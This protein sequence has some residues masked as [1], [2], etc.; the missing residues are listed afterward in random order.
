[1]KSKSFE[2][3]L[4]RL[5]MIMALLFL[6]IILPMNVWF[7]MY[8]LHD[9][10]RGS[11]EEMFGQ[12]EQ[13]MRLNTSELEDTR[14]EFKERCIQAADAVAFCVMLD[15][16][17]VNDREK[18]KE[19][20]KKLDIDEIHYF[21]PEG[22]IYE[23]THPKYFGYT[24]DSGE[25][26]SF[27]KPMLQDRTLK[28]CQ[29][30]TPNTAEGKEMQYAAV[31][32]EDGSGIVQIGMEPRRLQQEMEEKDLQNIIGSFPFE[33]NGY[34]HIIDK[35][36][37][38][39]VASTKNTMIGKEFKGR[40]KE[41]DTGEIHSLH[42]R[43]GGKKYC[44]YLKRYG[45]YIFVR[46]YES[47]D[48]FYT[49]L[50]S[51]VLIVIY[52]IL[53]SFGIIWMIRWYVKNKLV[54]GL[55]VINHELKKIEDGNMEKITLNTG[56]TEFEELLSYINRMLDNIRSNWN[57]FSYIMD[58]GGIPIGIYEKNRFYK[59]TF[60][61]E[62]MTEILGI[63]KRTMLSEEQI[64]RLVEEKLR[65]AEEKEVDAVE[66]VCEYDRDGDIRHL[67]IE[68]PEDEQSTI[69]YVTDI[70]FWWEEIT[71]VKE[72]SRM[73]ELTG[74]YNRRGFYEKMES[75][76]KNPETCG[77]AAMLMID[78]DSLKKINDTLG[79]N[80]GDQYLKAIAASLKKSSGEY[81]VCARL[82]GDEFVVFL[83]GFSGV[84]ELQKVILDMK[85]AR[86][87][88]FEEEMEQHGYHLQFSIGVSFYP[89]D[90]TDF[91]LLMQIADERMYQEKKIRKLRKMNL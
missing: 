51:S 73:D 47:I 36:T 29:D 27:F 57:K 65:Q 10:Q 59:K 31:W 34:L 26:M 91:H 25:Q 74:L 16:N 52:T 77:C 42:E 85:A 68:K 81:S 1:M 78:A 84:K 23:G 6:I 61:N 37:Q 60:V 13:L 76:L 48:A 7:Q 2:K 17:L 90:G 35:N 24:F 86:G 11:A 38:K 18:T 9:S 87:I 41:D 49:M 69:Y 20:A 21:T 72:Q 22:E 58:K 30:I 88:P 14:S 75:L 5:A 67:R 64:E 45:D 50:K 15:K 28:L 3:S 33:V 82:G 40:I 66:H 53:G 83:Y 79:H 55:N 80:I 8:I 4:P 62:R 12:L 63:E 70:S 54:S 19:L 56:I 44:V 43:Y 46:T 71:H 89:A 32:L 39:V